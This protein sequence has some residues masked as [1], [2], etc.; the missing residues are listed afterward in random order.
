MIACPTILCI[1]ALVFHRILD[2]KTGLDFYLGP[3]LNLSSRDFLFISCK[4]FQQQEGL[5]ILSLQL[6]Q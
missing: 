5:K 6:F 4:I 3:F 1:I 2:L